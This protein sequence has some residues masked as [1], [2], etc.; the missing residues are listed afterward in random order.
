MSL[1]PSLWFE[2]ALLA[3]LGYELWSVTR[4]RPPPPGQ[5]GEPPP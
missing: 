3:F 2:L 5:D 4:K 1:P